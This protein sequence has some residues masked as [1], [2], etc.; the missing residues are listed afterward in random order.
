MDKLSTA[1]DVMKVAVA[2][3]KAANSNNYCR[4]AKE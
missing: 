2:P 3:R 1:N 4:I